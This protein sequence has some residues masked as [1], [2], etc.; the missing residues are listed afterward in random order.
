MNE[1]KFDSIDGDIADL[2]SKYSFSSENNEIIM[3]NSSFF[4]ETLDESIEIFY[5]WM[6]EQ[7]NTFD[8]YFADAKLMITVKKLQ[9]SYW[10]TFF[11]QEINQEYI[12]SR[13]KVGQVHAQINLPLEIY[14][15][16][17]N[18]FQIIWDNIIS[19]KNFS[20]E[21]ELIKCIHRKMNIDSSIVSATY[22]MLTNKRIAD[23][24]RALL[25]MS[26]PVTLIWDRI[27]L[28]PIVGILDSKRTLDMMDS[29]LK[30]ISRSQAVVALID[31]SGVAVVDT[32]VA[33][34]LI[35]VTKATKLM[36]CETII[37]G[38]SPVI[39][40]TIVDLGIRI[41][42]IKTTAALK[43]ALSIALKK[44]EELKIENTNKHAQL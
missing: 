41:G 7:S 21:V 17:M 1:V 32:A 38:V 27:L 42:E 33:N 2:V 24:N 39:A 11:S 20:N 30:E 28:L 16:A 9:K 19:S 37:S 12:D 29:I 14:C 26:T 43:D 36:G 15:A 22:N 40:H 6:K 4:L 34:H 31:I 10:E 8:E 25:E 18:K 23:Q 3:K 5:T 13:K 44:V 35:K